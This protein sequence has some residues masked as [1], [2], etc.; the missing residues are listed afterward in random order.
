MSDV[1]HHHKSW[2]EW[3]SHALSREP[4]DRQ[5][6]LE[7]LR[8]AKQR[9][10]FSMDAL[11]MIEGVLQVSE[12][13]VRD[14]MIPRVNMIVVE[15]KSTPQE[16]L[17]H[18]SQ[19]GH[20]RYPVIGENRD[21][22]L[23]ILLAKDLLRSC[24]NNAKQPL[25]QELIRPAVFIPES[26]RLDILLK[27]FRLNRNHM[28]IVVDE[29]GGIAG[30]VTIEDVLEQIVGDIIDEHDPHA[31]EENIRKL[32]KNEYQVKALTPLEEINEHLNCQFDIEEFDTIGGLVMQRFGYLPKRDETIIIEPLEIKVLQTSKRRVDKLLIS[33]QDPA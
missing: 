13:Q 18:I 25:I 21:E 33:V 11:R 30:L 27:E 3:I 20:S 8:D 1:D 29:Y 9:Q 16:A 5:E 26:K 15:G 32:G 7:L 22:I 14:I 6:L 24:L 12:M 10:L 23:G 28:A 31:D 2:I 17:P 19:Y 4:Q